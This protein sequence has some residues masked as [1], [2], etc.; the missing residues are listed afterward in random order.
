MLNSIYLCQDILIVFGLQP[1]LVPVACPNTRSQARPDRIKHKLGRVDVGWTV[2][3]TTG[4]VVAE[5]AAVLS[6]VSKVDRLAARFKKQ[7]LVKSLDE[8]L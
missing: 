1:Q 3:A 8:Q 6:D 4:E 5:N 2:R 7:E